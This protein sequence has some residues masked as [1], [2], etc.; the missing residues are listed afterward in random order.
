MD[1]VQLL[2]FHQKKKMSIIK[3]CKDFHAAGQIQ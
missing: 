1:F 2:D 3:V